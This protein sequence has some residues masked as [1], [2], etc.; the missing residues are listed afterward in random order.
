MVDYVCADRAVFL[1]AGPVKH[2]LIQLDVFTIN[3]SGDT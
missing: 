2:H 3:T 1:R